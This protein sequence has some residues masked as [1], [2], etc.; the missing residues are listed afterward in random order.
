VSDD[1]RR[2]RSPRLTARRRQ[3]VLLLT[4]SASLGVVALYQLGLIRHLPEPP[5]PFLDADRVDAAGE[6]Y[7]LGLTPDALLGVASAATSLTLVSMEAEDRAERRPIIP[8]LAAAKLAADAAGGLYL[9]AEQLS[10]HRRLCS[11]CLVAAVAQAA[12]F[13]FAVPEAAQ[14]LRRLRR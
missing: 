14:A 10:Q 3:A 6:A 8:L 13:P 11:W 5:L 12:A 7:V 9:T 1:L 4:A 2:G